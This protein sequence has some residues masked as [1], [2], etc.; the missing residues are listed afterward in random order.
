MSQPSCYF[1]QHQ[2]D[3]SSS[4]TSAIKNIQDQHSNLKQGNITSFMDGMNSN[5]QVRILLLFNLYWLSVALLNF[6][7]LKSWR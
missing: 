1:L 4:S 6:I 3:S 7:N 2:N 5:E